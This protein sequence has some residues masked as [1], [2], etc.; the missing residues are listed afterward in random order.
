[1]MT[2]MTVNPWELGRSVM[3]SVETWDNGDLLGDFSVHVG[4][5]IFVPEVCVLSS[6]VASARGCVC[7]CD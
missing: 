6:W 5:P 7:P 3:K 2:G 4:S 1:M